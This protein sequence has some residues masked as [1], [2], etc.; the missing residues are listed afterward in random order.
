MMDLAGY[1]RLIVRNA[2]E[3]FAP[4]SAKQSRFSY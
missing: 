1:L 4:N 2:L 3:A